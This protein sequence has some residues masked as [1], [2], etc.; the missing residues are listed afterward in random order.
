M[1][2]VRPLPDVTEPQEPAE[3]PSPVMVQYLEIKAANP[4]SLLF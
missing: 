2:A 4:D 1:D 3:R